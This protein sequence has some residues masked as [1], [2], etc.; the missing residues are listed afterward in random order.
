MRIKR[1]LMAAALIGIMFCYGCGDKDAKPATTE[2]SASQ[3]TVS[4]STEA[5][6]S[7]A[8]SVEE[9]SN[10][11]TSISEID[12]YNAEEA[13][14][15]YGEVTVTGIEDWNCVGY[16]IAGFMDGSLFQLQYVDE[17]GTE[18]NGDY[19]PGAPDRIVFEFDPETG[20]VV[21]ATYFGTYPDEEAAGMAVEAASANSDL[22]G[23]DIV[24]LSAA[25][26][27]IMVAFDPHS[28]RFN[29]TIRTYFLEGHQDPE[30]YTKAVEKDY[31]SS[32][33][34]KSKLKGDNF[35]CDAI[36]GLKVTWYK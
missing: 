10:S 28:A 21:S 3:E 19:T 13:Y 23:G 20:E 11:E 32:T 14:D 29:N 12:P 22:M 5:S 35:A 1:L 6:T 8:T 36:Q 7:E 4:E 16:S 27:E 2:T 34:D 17:N 9:T 18:I 31:E 24:G 15:Y 26:T 25:G 30:G 33:L